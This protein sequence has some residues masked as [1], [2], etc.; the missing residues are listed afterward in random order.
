MSDFFLIIYKVCA[1][2]IFVAAGVFVSLMIAAQI[3]VSI[4]HVAWIAYYVAAVALIWLILEYGKRNL[5][6]WFSCCEIWFL[7]L[8]CFAVH[9][10]MV[11]WLPE[12]GQVGMSAPGDSRAALM[13]LNADKICHMHQPRDINWSNYEVLLSALGALWHRSLSFGQMLNGVVHIMVLFPIYRISRQLC[14]NGI[15]RLTVILVAFSPTVIAY[16]ALLA[17]ECLSS[18][19]LFYAAYFFVKAVDDDSSQGNVVFAAVMCGI[20]LGF[21]NLFKTISLIFIVAMVVSLVLWIMREAGYRRAKRSIMVFC[22]VMVFQSLSM[23]VGQ[24]SLAALARDNELINRETGESVFVYEFLIGLDVEHDGMFSAKLIKKIRSWDEAERRRQLR[25]AI[26]RD[27]RSYPKLMVRKFCNIHGSHSCP[28]GAISHFSIMIGDW[29][30]KECGR[31]VAP[32]ICLI[33]DNSTFVLRVLLFLGAIGALFARGRS[34]G[35]ALPG[36][37]SM[38]VVL[39][40][41]AVEQLIEGHGRYKVAVYPFYFMLVPYIC[42]WFERENSL[43]VRIGGLF[44]KL[45]ERRV[46]HEY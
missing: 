33:S 35:F 13:A 27:W 8:A 29:P 46:A 40:F 36:I 34:F 15:A 14:G 38:L 17:S 23:F 24:W 20:F 12:F 6:H 39:S 25:T 9:Y 32:L 1:A 45:N 7:A 16:S 42:V 4:P 43:Y 41:A 19:L 3:C 44:N 26:K 37:F 28:A 31:Y 2:L 5:G 22:I 21:S 30:R 18:M 10:A 11:V